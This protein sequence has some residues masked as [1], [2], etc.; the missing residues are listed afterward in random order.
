MAKKNFSLKPQAKIELQFFQEENI[1]VIANW[2]LYL[3]CGHHVQLI[4]FNSTY[5]E[6]Y[7]SK[8]GFSSRQHVYKFPWNVKGGEEEESFTAAPSPFSI[9]ECITL[10]SP[11]LFLG[12][13]QN[14]QTINFLKQ[15]PSLEWCRRPLLFFFLSFLFHRT[16][17]KL[18]IEFGK[19][20]RL[21]AIILQRVPTVF[22]YGFF[23]IKG[24]S[25]NNVIGNFF[26]F[27]SS[28]FF[29]FF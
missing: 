18:E 21:I 15:D 27:R 14:L 9:I 17:W 13:N 22:V 20:F 6:I 5:E 16:K 23:Q 24:G 25:K 2:K 8:S 26:S 28:S 11:L 7:L 3:D 12:G 10:P 19:H 1:L 29:F 4:L